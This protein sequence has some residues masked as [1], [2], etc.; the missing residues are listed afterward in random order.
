MPGKQF[1]NLGDRLARTTPETKEVVTR[2]PCVLVF[3]VLF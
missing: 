3:N 2:I 1:K